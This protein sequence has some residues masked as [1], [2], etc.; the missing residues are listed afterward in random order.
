M[1]P[2]KRTRC[3]NAEVGEDESDDEDVVHRQG[4]FDDISR[5]EFEGFLPATQRT[6]NQGK[7]HREGKPDSGPKEG[8]AEF[9]NVRPAVDDA[10]I[11]AEENENENDESQPVP[12]RD[13]N[14]R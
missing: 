1:M 7:K 2:Q 9:D 5:Q 6:Q 11:N 12:P 4:K 14:Q 10:E 8:L 13:L 3:W